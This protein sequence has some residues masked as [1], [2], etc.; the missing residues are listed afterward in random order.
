MIALYVTF[1]VV[2]ILIFALSIFG[3]L[4]HEIDLSHSMDFAHHDLGDHGDHPGIF[5]VRTIAA[6]LAGF[7]VSGLTSK[8][9]L[10]WGIGGQLALGFGTGLA[11]AG[12]AILVMRLIYS[13]QCGSIKDA[14]TLVGKTAIISISS[15]EQGI[16]EC[17][18]DNYYYSCKE[19]NNDALRKNDS[20]RIVEVQPG[21]LI[22][23]KIK[24]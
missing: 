16:A 9:F 1:S 15:G 4:E 6:F 10:N 7:G 19:K 5:S 8:V 3:G 14:N 11:L 18:A 20:T 24:I 2:G 21:M 22:V 23:E 12:F 13:Q 17:L